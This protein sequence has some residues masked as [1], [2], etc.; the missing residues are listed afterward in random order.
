[1]PSRLS[2]EPRCNAN[3]SWLTGNSSIRMMPNGLAKPL[4]PCEYCY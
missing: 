2:E 1:M 3:V 4:N